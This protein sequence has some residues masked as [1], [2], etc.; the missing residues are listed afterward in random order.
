M[1]PALAAPVEGPLESVVFG[2]GDTIR[3]V[4]ER[5]LR[6][7]DLWPQILELS[8]I[9]SP[10]D[11][12]PGLALK[13]P[14]QQVAAADEALAFSLAAIQ[15]ATAEGARIFA[16]V[17][18]G[19]AIENRDTA[20]ERRGVGAWAEVVTFAGVATEFADRAL[21]IS[22]AQR[23]RAAEA[24]VSDAQ[25]TVEGR[26]P[27]QPRW[28]RR[29]TQDVLV[30]YERL[31]TLSAS[32]AQVTF[33]DLSRLRLNPNSNAVIQR[34]RSDPLTGG[35]VTKVN[36]VNGDFYALLNQLG[37]RTSFEVAVPGIETATQSA[38][39]WIRHDEAGSRFAN[40]DAPALEISRGGERISIGENEGAVLPSG[41]GAERT[42]VLAQTELAAPLDGAEI[43]T[44][45]VTLAWQPAEGAEGYWLEI[46]ADAG[47]N[48]MQASQWGVRDTSRQ[49]DG[50]DPGDHYW[51]VSSLDRLGL[52]GVRSL[53]R[54]FRIVDDRTPPFVT[55]ATPGEGEIVTVA[56]V[57]VTGEAEPG[58]EVSLNGAPVPVADDG[59]FSV[60][61]APAEG[62]NVLR[63]A[64]VDRAGNRTERSRAFVYR[65][66]GT[67]G[68][69][70]DPA[71]PRDAEGRLLSASP[72]FAVAGTSTAEAGASLRVVA[73]DGSVA[74]QTL[75]DS[76]GAFHVTLPATE[77]G[78]AY[79]IEILAADRSVAGTLALA[80]RRDA[81]PPGIALDLPPRAT[82]NAWLEVTGAAEGA[83]TVTVNGS[84][85]RMDGDRFAATATLVP[86]TNG[87]EIVATDAVG[88]VAV[89]RVE[90]TY[91]ID[92]PEIVAARADR[93]GGPAGPIEIVVEARDASGLRQA[94][95]FV[96]SVGGVERRGF[97]RCDDTAG[98]CRETLPPEPG[99]LVLVEVTVEDYAGNAARR[100]P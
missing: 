7:A 65:P 80:A 61:L 17:E 39:F 64:A 19:H 51:R 44:P 11:L 41:G 30:E 42:R 93:P 99:A 98:V 69:A 37:D 81:T 46:A 73:A 100:Q 45:D 82:A 9:A 43:F 23:D 89:K 66:V 72:E 52:P 85:A 96:L 1:A 5:Y 67:V 71:L 47:F 86:G 97:L 20:V 18:I 49:F 59:A 32:T 22:V 13:V 33:R 87:I 84:P 78:A 36:L 94:A 38:D 75:T 74:V 24:V 63:L 48:V 3:G 35:E 10:A 68:I 91:D 21:E 53:S 90:T 60:T 92:P 12:R 70:L 77:A 28:S 4:A 14:V 54:H 25:G 62:E 34:M 50:L 76:G 56:E 29:A 83:Q 31:R 40:Y 26:A 8:G 6:D 55:L 27:D 2:P 88:N 95:P 58:A 15:K 57:A 79:R 16:P